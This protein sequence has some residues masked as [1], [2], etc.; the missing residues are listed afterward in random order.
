MAKHFLK[1]LLLF[2]VIIV[3]GMGCIVLT[4]VLEK[5]GTQ[6]T[7]TTNSVQVAK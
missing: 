1:A 3:L 5:N 6:T 2:V 7:N 4:S